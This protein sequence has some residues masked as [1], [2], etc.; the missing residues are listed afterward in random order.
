MAYQFCREFAYIVCI[1]GTPAIFGLQVA[2]VGPAQLLQ[3]LL[4]GGDMALPCGSSAAKALRTPMRRTRSTCC[5]RIAHGHATIEPPRN[6]M[7]SRRLICLPLKLK[8]RHR[9]ELHQRER[10]KL[11]L[12]AAINHV[13]FTPEAEIRQ[14][15]ENVHSSV[16]GI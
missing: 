14:R 2:A 4:E 9:T 10:I 15:S 11:A 3:P 8:R 1:A 13:R 12:S 6:V 7:N 16:F 5:A